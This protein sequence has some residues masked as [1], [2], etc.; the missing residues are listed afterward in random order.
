MPPHPST[1]YTSDSTH[2][3]IIRMA[4]LSMLSIFFLFQLLSSLLNKA[5]TPR[6]E[7]MLDVSHVRN[8]KH[9]DDELWCCHS[10]GITVYSFDLKELRNI[11]LD[12]GRTVYGV[13]SLNVN[14]VVIATDESLSTCSKRGS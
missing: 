10:R 4:V 6:Q 5:L 3:L 11:R 2:V 8:L 9:I 12:G 14:D 7:V 1:C 13:A